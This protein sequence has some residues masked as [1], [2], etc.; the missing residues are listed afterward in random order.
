MAKKP[1]KAKA[2][3]AKPVVIKS[4]KGFDRDLKC[5]GYQFEIGQTYDHSGAVKQCAS[6]FHACPVEHHPLS[7]FEFYA[8][9]GNRFC[10]V[11]Q[12]GETSNGGTKLAS[13]KITI[14]RSS[15]A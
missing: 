1:T 2:E 8:P 6:G 14:G 9:A 5:R 3:T 12:S 7:V 11:S 13:A 15:W 10:E 4:I